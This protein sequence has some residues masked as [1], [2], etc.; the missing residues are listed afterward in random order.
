MS[1]PFAFRAMAKPVFTSREIGADEEFLKFIRA[2][3]QDAQTRIFES[4]KAIAESLEALA[5]AERM[6]S[7]Q[8]DR[9][10]EDNGQELEGRP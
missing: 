3:S 1:Q 7:A 8:I 2:A 5:L 9:P 10:R 6:L 4:R